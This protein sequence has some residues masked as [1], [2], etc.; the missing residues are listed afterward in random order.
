VKERTAAIARELGLPDNASAQKVLDLVNQEATTREQAARESVLK[1]HQPGGAAWST[2][3]DSWKAETLADQTL[4]T[5][6]EERTA[7]V[8]KG[9]QVIDRFEKA[10]PEMGKAM[11]QFLN[12]SGLGEKREVVH[13]FTWLGKVA[14]EKPTVVPSGGSSGGP[15]S[16]VAQRYIDA[17]MNP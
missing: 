9:A 11:K 16:A 4:G 13:F 7:A 6:P 17:G 2:M 5:T 14:G 10:N 15:G 12:A 1:D 8:Q 3:L